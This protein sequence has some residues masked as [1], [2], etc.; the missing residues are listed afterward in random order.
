MMSAPC[1]SSGARQFDFWLGNWAVSWPAEQ[2]GGEPR[3]T[4]TGTNQVTKLF[5]DCIIEERFVTDDGS[6]AGRSLS[7]YDEQEDLWHQTWVDSEGGYITFTG[8]MDGD[9]MV[10]STSRVETESGVEVNRMVFSD[11]AEDSLFW[12][13]Q[14]SLNGGDTW[15][16]RWTITY[17]RMG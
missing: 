14:R 8:G 4:M 7:A 9:I 2:A 12:V 17:R 6:F 10:L 5:G 3:T 15:F 11:I 1:S 13:W 16:D